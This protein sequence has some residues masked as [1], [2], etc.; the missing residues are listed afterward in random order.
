[1]AFAAPGHYEDFLLILQ[2]CSVEWTLPHARADTS[3]TFSYW[4][5]GVL[6]TFLAVVFGSCDSCPE[7]ISLSKDVASRI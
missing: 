5:E 3:K 7:E 2:L 4:N 6:Y 1:L